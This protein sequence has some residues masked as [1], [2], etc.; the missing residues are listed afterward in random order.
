MKVLQCIG[1]N[2][3][4]KQ[5]PI[6]IFN[7]YR[8]V[9][10]NWPPRLRHERFWFTTISK[11]CDYSLIHW[12]IWTLYGWIQCWLESLVRSETTFKLEWFVIEIFFSAVQYWCQN[13]KFSTSL[14]RCR[15]WRR[16]SF[17]P[18]IFIGIYFGTFLCR[19]QTGCTESLR[20][21]EK[22]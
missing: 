15:F 20:M 16:T 18:A 8:R 9:F 2:C 13:A 10:L 5:L 21:S 12:Y 17:A 19:Q 22:V 1:Q 14:M 11:V 6:E 3:P 4:T 7:Y